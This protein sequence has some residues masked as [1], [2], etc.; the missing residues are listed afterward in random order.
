MF[1][2]K[3]ENY[4]IEVQSIG[5]SNYTFICIKYIG[6]IYTRTEDATYVEE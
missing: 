2:K 3:E 1:K 5:R 4:V 6:D